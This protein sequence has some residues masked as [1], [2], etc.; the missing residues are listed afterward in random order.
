MPHAVIM[1]RT[2]PC[3]QIFRQYPLGKPFEDVLYSL[4]VMRMPRS[5]HNK[6]PVSFS[7]R[8]GIHNQVWNQQVYL[9]G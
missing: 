4:Q 6:E 7:T 1:H 2:G 5:L 3:L 8:N 9:C